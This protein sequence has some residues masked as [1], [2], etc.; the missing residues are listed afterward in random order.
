MPI[1]DYERR[2]GFTRGVAAFTL[3]PPLIDAT[4]I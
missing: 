4:H 3:N 1:D 2:K